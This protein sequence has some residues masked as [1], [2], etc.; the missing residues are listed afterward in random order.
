VRPEELAALQA[1][2]EQMVAALEAAELRLDALR[3][4]LVRE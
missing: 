3:V 1:D 4:V 2:T